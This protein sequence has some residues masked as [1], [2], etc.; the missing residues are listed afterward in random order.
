MPER[1][2]NQ[3]AL[4]KQEPKWQESEYKKERVRPGAAVFRAQ[5]IKKVQVGL[6]EKMPAD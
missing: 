5:K 2:F 3:I 1:I 6:F 4:L